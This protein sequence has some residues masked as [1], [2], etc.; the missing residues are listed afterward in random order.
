MTRF[1]LGVSALAIAATPVLASEQ[2]RVTGSGTVYPFTAAVAEAFGKASG[3]KTPVVEATG[4]GPG[5]KLFCTGA[6]D[7]TPDFADA[8][9]A[10]KKDELATCM[11]NGVKEVVQLT[12]GYDGIALTNAK[13]GPD[14]S[15]TKQQ[16]YLALAKQVPDK[17]GKLVDNPYKMWSDIDPSLPKVKI[18]VLSHP[19]TSGTRSS[20]EDLILKPGAESFPAMKDLEAKDAKAF[21]A[22]FKTLRTDGGFVE[23]GENDN[24]IIQK[25]EADPTVFALFGYSNVALNGSKIKAAKVEGE[26][27]SVEAVQAGKY[28][29]S[30]PLFVYAKKDHLK[31]TPDMA[32]FV[33]EYMSAKAIGDDGYLADKGL[34]PLPAAE[35]KKQM[36]LAKAMTPLTADDLK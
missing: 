21:D 2:I 10:M 4:S 20:I 15:V 9:R 30:R 27:P 29:L 23:A 18:T 13:G 12:I 1:L 22:A 14:I 7:D 11:T 8:S 6:G 16:I 24:A 35:L 17:D 33:A 25:L 34:I 31:T 36:D 28:K 5:I 3:K 26:A 19:A 32:A